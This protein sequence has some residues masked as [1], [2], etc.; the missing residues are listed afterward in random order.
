MPS[1]RDTGPEGHY[2]VARHHAGTMIQQFRKVSLTQVKLEYGRYTTAC[3]LSKD[4]S[5]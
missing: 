5:F 3:V 4:N 2:T 1:M